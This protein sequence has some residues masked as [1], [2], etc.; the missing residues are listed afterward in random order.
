M[1][2]EIC[3]AGN[4]LRCLD[5]GLQV[6]SNENNKYALINQFNALFTAGN[7]QFPPRLPQGNCGD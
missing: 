2:A 5:Y 6:K 3:S 1:I 7:V 4:T